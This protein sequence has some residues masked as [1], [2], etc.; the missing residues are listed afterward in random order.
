[1]RQASIRNSL[2]GE[3]SHSSEVAQLMTFLKDNQKKN[4]KVTKEE[5]NQ[6]VQLVEAL[7]RKPSV[8]PSVE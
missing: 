3:L 7:D 4:K 2:R 1:M 5:I 8:K 6:L